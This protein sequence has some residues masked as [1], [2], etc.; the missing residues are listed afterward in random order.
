MLKSLFQNIKIEVT[1]IMIRLILFKIL[2][3][4]SAFHS[5]VKG[6]TKDSLV[7]YKEYVDTK[8][9]YQLFELKHGHYIKTDNVNMHYLTWGDSTKQPIVWIHGTN[10]NAYELYEIAD[11]MVSMGLYV[12]AIDFYGHGETPIPSKQV[13]LYHVADDINYLL[14]ALKL[15]TTIIGGWSRGGS[16]ATAFYDTYPEKVLGIVLEDGGSVAWDTKNHKKSI[17]SL[18]NEFTRNYVNYS[19]SGSYKSE[20]DLFKRVYKYHSKKPSFHRTIFTIYSA[21]KKDT[22]DKYTLN[23]RLANFI[24]EQSAKDLLMVVHRPFAA[25]S[26]FGASTHL[27][28]PK[29]IYRNLRIP[30]LILDPVSADDWFDFEE[31]NR[32]LKNE[33]PEWITHIVYPN[34]GHAVKEE[35]TSAFLNDLGKFLRK[36]KLLYKQE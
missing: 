29:I 18:T 6:Q 14:N 25:E 24:S 36:H 22:Q 2:W 5:F 28:Y 19:P 35:H 16:I 15:K 7:I 10:G 1:E 21:L 30:M 13:S 4:L 20:Y 8:I 27:L 26:L 32:Q 23:P 9:A 3:I 33:H 17:D 11:S 34:T 12:I 31:E